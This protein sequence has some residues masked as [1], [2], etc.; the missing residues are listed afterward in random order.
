MTASAVRWAFFD[1]LHHRTG[2]A[3]PLW[4]FATLPEKLEAFQTLSRSTIATTNCTRTSC[5]FRL[6]LCGQVFCHALAGIS[7]GDWWTSLSSS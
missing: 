1:T 4:H 3:P 7:S 5:S 2:V 6:C